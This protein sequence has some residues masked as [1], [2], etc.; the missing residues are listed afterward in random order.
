MTADELAWVRT[1]T[2]C[3]GILQGLLFITLEGASIRHHRTI[4]G[5]SACYEN[6]CS[7]VRCGTRGNPR[8]HD[9]LPELRDTDVFSEAGL[10]TIIGALSAKPKL[11]VEFWKTMLVPFEGP[12]TDARTV[13]VHVA[14]RSA[15][16]CA[17]T[18]CCLFSRS[19]QPG[20]Q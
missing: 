6:D 15:M 1:T 14:G 11:V 13:A 9:S 3:V 5:Q 20:S 4:G 2:G 19:G 7:P 17:K 18:S 16:C 10:A 8:R 12:V